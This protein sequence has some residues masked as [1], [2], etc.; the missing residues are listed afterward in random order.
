MRIE[1]RRTLGGLM[2][3]IALLAVPLA[4]FM[5]HIRH[6]QQ[7]QQRQALIR[8]LEERLDA[9]IEKE[10]SRGQIMTQTN[11]SGFGVPPK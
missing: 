3:L 4:I 10:S 5:R 7:V 8:K 2:I 6:I 9:L 1:R 11:L